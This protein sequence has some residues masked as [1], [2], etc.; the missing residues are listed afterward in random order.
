M[1]NLHKISTQEIVQK[2]KD[3]E[4]TPEQAVEQYAPSKRT[5]AQTSIEERLK[6]YEK[7]KLIRTEI[8]RNKIPF[9]SETFLPNFYLSQG[10]VLVGAESGKSKSTTAA[11][12]IA[13][14]LRA[15]DGTAIVITNEEATDAII[16]RIACVLCK[17]SYIDFYNKK[18]VHKDYNLVFETIPQV[19]S[20]VEVVES[21]LWDTAYIEDIQAVL[22]TA[23]RNKVGLVLIDYLQTITMS[24]DRPELES[25]QISKKLGFYFK[26]YGKKNGVPVVVLAQLST[27]S[28]GRSMSDRVQNDKTIY[29]H[30]FIAIEVVP[31]FKTLSTTFKIHKTRFGDH[32]GQEV[33][34]S[35]SGGRYFFNTKHGL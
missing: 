28:E 14:Y 20:R 3:G 13:G 21:G 34:M 5:Y 25:F 12:V 24:R 26:D 27:S 6:N 29:N 19:I 8:L 15:T 31:D 9:I 33:V 7:N 16:E 10:L 30:S 4:L 32:S 22:E 18:L 17:I 35:Y 23:A 11:N 1:N 2:V